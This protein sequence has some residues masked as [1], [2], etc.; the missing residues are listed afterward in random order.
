MMMESMAANLTKKVLARGALANGGARRLLS[1]SRGAFGVRPEGPEFNGFPLKNEE[2]YRLFFEDDNGRTI[3][4]W[5]DVPLYVNKEQ[6]IVNFIN[7]IPRGSV[8]KME[9]AT[10][11]ELNPI[12]QDTKKGKLRLYPFQ[13]LVNYGCLPQTWE[14]PEH[15][16]ASTGMLGDNDPVDVV[17]VGSKVAEMGAIYPVKVLGIL[18]MI[19]E[20]EMDWKTIAIAADDPLAEHINTVADLEREMP[21]KVKSIVDWFKFYK[22][23]DGKPENEFAFDDQAKDEAFA[24]DVIELTYKSWENTSNVTKAGLWKP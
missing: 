8:E 17:E 16:D 11:E 7:E 19:D 15:K 1:A 23:P 12:K 6:R 21:G 24:M 4:P 9:I 3:S 18:G 5:H 20:G 10:D 14:D 2:A 22:M 13:S